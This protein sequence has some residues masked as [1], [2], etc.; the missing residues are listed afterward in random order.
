[1]IYRG[2]LLSLLIETKRFRRNRYLF[3]KRKKQKSDL[4]LFL[5]AMIIPQMSKKSN[6]LLKINL[7]FI[8]SLLFFIFL[9]KATPPLGGGG[10]RRY[11]PSSSSKT[12][13]N[14]SALRLL[15]SNI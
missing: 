13:P 5:I 1:M 10:G 9:G 2:L 11:L 3:L 15:L 4:F 8:S 12:N 14:I 7:T 6:P